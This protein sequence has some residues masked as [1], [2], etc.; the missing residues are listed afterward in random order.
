MRVRIG[1][2]IWVLRLFRALKFEAQGLK[3]CGSSSSSSSSSS[4]SR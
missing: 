2:P 3:D 1:L 4:G